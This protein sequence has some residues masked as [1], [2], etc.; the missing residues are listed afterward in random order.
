M[1]CRLVNFSVQTKCE[2]ARFDFLRIAE[3]HF[4]GNRADHRHP[5]AVVDDALHVVDE[6][7]P[8]VAERRAALEGRP[9][10]LAELPDARLDAFLAQ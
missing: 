1:Q 9:R 4:D 10:D 5:V 6:E 3:L 7:L 2:F 8:L